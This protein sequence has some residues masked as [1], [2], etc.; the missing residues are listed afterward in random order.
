MP[1][2]ARPAITPSPTLPAASA[3]STT[4]LSPPRHLR[5][6]ADRVAILDVDLHH[7]NGTQGIF[8]AC[9][10]VLTVSLHADPERFYPFFWGHADERG[11]APASAK[12]Q[13]AAAAQSPAT[14]HY[15]AH[16]RGTAPHSRLR[17]SGA[18]GGA[19]SRRLRGR[20]FRRPLGDDAGL[21]GDRATAI[22]GL[23]LPTVIVQEG[24][25][26]AM[27]YRTTSPPS[28]PASWLTRNRAR[29]RRR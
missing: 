2:A 4:R 22:A 11:E 25:I 9:D 28:S 6:Q 18:G 24:A 17:A 12:P 29:R 5:R 14:R 27:R 15:S 3:S 16:W 20:S 8:Y 1:S 7:G 13:P 19:R 26:S 21:L 10:D 23:G